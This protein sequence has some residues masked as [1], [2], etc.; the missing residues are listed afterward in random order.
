MHGVA[1][2]LD[3]GM[4]IASHNFFSFFFGIIINNSLRFL[5]VKIIHRES[6][7]IAI[8]LVTKRY[9]T[10]NASK[11]SSNR[12]FPPHPYTMFHP[13]VLGRERK[14]NKRGR[15][16]GASW[17]VNETSTNPHS[18]SSSIAKWIARMEA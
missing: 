2:Q 6:Y 8:N 13:T 9:D 1:F 18:S 16:M 10:Q 12:K 14:I 3:K 11:P 5:D 17:I 15:G 7:F 4:E